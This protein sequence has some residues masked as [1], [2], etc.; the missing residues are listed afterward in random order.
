[1]KGISFPLIIPAGG[2]ARG[3]FNRTDFRPPPHTYRTGWT[4]DGPALL[5]GW[6]WRGSGSAGISRQRRACSG[7]WR[8]SLRLGFNSFGGIMRSMLGRGLP[9][10]SGFRR[11]M[12]NISVRL[13]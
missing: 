6:R 1:M 11:W 4:P 13:D 10:S 3:F 5:A 7:A 9:I 8:A 12:D 2:F